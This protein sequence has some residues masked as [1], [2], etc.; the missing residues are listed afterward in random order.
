MYQFSRAIYRELSPLIGDSKLAN[1]A[2]DAR[3]VVLHECEC[4]IQRLFTDRR[5]FARPARTLFANV[6]PYFAISDL[7]HVF[8]SIQRNMEVAERFLEGAP[9]DITFSDVARHCQATTRK[10]T[11]CRRQPLPRSEYCPSHQHLTESFEDLTLDERELEGLL[12]PAR[13]DLAA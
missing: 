12:T 8:R 3:R 11:P 1:N 10:G 9:D 7:S 2:V 5:H 6:R 13:L 4:A